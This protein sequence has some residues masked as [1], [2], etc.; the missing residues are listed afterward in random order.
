[1]DGRQ[2]PRGLDRRSYRNGWRKWEAFATGH[3]ATTL[4][5]EPEALAAF[6]EHLADAFTW[7]QIERRPDGS[8]TITFRCPKTDADTTAYLAPI[9]V[10]ALDAIR[11]EGY[12]RQAGFD[13]G[14]PGNAAPAW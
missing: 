8:A 4:P 7:K 12:P 5:G 1:M 11:R 3:G 14:R 6:V 9:T 13:S 10:A 2:F